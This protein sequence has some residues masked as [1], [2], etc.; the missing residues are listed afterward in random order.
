MQQRIIH[1]DDDAPFS[2][3]LARR[4]E[5]NGWECISFLTIDAAIASHAQAPIILLDLNLTEGSSLQHLNR[6][7]ETWPKAKIIILTGYASIATTVYAIK[8]GA[9]DYLS[10]PVEMQTLLQVLHQS[11][12]GSVS[13]KD[14][15]ALS[16]ESISPEALEWELIQKTLAQ[17]QGNISQTARVLGMHRRTLQ[18]KL[19]KKSPHQRK[20]EKPSS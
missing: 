8:N 19:Q 4:L 17:H 12:S 6:I 9:H 13:T 11:L 15:P 10:K 7:A 14:I 16:D 1:I 2:Q 18:R 20:N 3:I 5:R